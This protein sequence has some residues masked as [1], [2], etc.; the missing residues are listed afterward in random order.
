MTAQP[1]VDNRPVV[2]LADDE[3]DV[4]GAVAPFLERS[5]LRVITAP[6]GKLA[7]DEIRRHKPDVCV[8][9]VLMPGADGREV[10]RTLRREENWVPVLLLTQVG[11]AVERAMALE[12]GADDYLN[13]PFDPHELVARIRAVLR[14]TRHDG[15]PLATAPVL[16]STFGLRLDR[17]SRRVWL[18]DRELVITPKGVTLLEYLMVHRDELIERQRLLEVLWGFDDAV[19]TRAVDSR[20]AELRRVLGED[21]SNPRWIGTVQGRGY[22]FVAEVTGAENARP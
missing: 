15:P 17:T 20:V 21:A 16:V 2:V 11:E 7:L 5:G 22:R 9:D 18:G 19:G 6:D 1:G 8:L 3:P 4:L 14:R 13:K 12:E 10:L